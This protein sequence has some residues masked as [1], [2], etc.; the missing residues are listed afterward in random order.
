MTPAAHHPGEP[1]A[2]LPLSVAIVCCNN[3]ATI[4]RT[5]RSVAG[6]AAEIV[7]VDSGSTD[8]TLELLARAGARTIH[9]PWLGHIRQKQAALDACTQ[10]WILHL[11]SDESLEPDLRA[12]IADTIRRDDPAIGACAMIRKVWYAGRFLDH[13]WQPEWRT[14]LV[15]RSV[16]AWG[17]YDPHDALDLTPDSRARYRVARIPGVMRH[18]S[19]GRIGDFLAKQA[20]HARIAAESY[21]RLGRKASVAKLI[22]SPAGT[23]AKQLILKSAWRDGWRGWAAA[24]AAASGAFMKHAIL[25]ERTMLSSQPTSEALHD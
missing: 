15:R 18:D 14:R 5:L 8:A 21:Q 20:S 9:Q 22:T 10:P 16:A 6:L 1:S 11:D 23:L 2:P 17:G 19:I 3:Q 12:A 24:G 13:T 7:A 4:G 25:L